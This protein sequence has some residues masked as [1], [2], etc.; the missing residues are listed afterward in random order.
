MRFGGFR[1]LVRGSDPYALAFNNGDLG[2]LFHSLCGRRVRVL[3]PHIARRVQ[4]VRL[5]VGHAEAQDKRI[6]RQRLARIL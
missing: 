5:G 4:S 1:E 3:E 6:G 2:L